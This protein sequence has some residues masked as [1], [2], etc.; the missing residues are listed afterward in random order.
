MRRMFASLLLVLMGCSSYDSAD[1]A[2]EAP[3]DGLPAGTLR[4]DVTPPAVDGGVSLL[5]QSHI[6]P[7]DGYQGLDIGLYA[8][9]TLGGTLTAQVARAWSLGAPTTPEPLVAGILALPEGNLHSAIAQS[10]D[11]GSYLLSFPDYPTLIQIAFVPIDATLAPVLVLDAPSVDGPGW[12]QEILPGI[13]VYGRV[14]GQVGGEQKALGGVTLRISRVVGGRIVNSAAFVTDRTGWYVGRVDRLGDYSIELEGGTASAVNVVVPALS[15]PVLVEATEG[16]EVP[17]ELGQVDEA[18]ADGSV[19]DTDGQP[20]VGARVRFTSISLDSGVGSLQVE[21]E[22]TRP[23]ANFIARL[24]PGVYDID[25]MPEYDAKVVASPVRYAGQRITDGASLP[26]LSVQPPGRLTGRVLDATEKPVADVQVVATEQGFGGN[27][28][29]GRTG[30]EGN[31]DFAVTDVPLTLTLT[32]AQGSAGAVTTVDIDAPEGN[33]MLQLDDGVPL[34][35]TVA[36]D[37]AP[38]GY[39]SV[40][41]YDARSNLLLGRTVTDDAGR[42]SLRISLPEVAAEADDTA[43]DTAG[44]TAGDTATARDTADDDTAADSGS[45]TAV[46]A[47]ADP[48][49]TAR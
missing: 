4:L 29:F 10:A 38:V 37:G 43:E 40:D 22:A 32:P 1:S 33:R 26:N 36:Y 49:D 15:V 8:T 3:L 17:I 41:V 28:Y 42:F 13:P 44:D 24:L 35:G 25:I 34:S 2:R 30:R 12:D 6:V 5:P 39:A 9:R 31:F 16:I 27:V 46:D 21:T 20:V 7:P 47:G 11:D 45:D 14:T 18:S 23:D 19:V 48:A